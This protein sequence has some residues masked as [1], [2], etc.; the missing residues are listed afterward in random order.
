MKKFD[1][2]R[3]VCASVAMATVF[4][5]SGFVFADETDA[6]ED[7]PVDVEQT[8]VA[9]ETEVELIDEEDGDDVVTEDPVAEE[10]PE[11]IDD[12]EVTDEE[13][14]DETE[15]AEDEEEAEVEVIDEEVII[16]EDVI[17][18][19]QIIAETEAEEIIEIEEETITF[20]EAEAKNG[21]QQED[22]SWY[23]YVNGN[24]VSGWKK[25]GK[26]WYYFDPYN[27]NRMQ[28]G[29]KDIEGKRFIFDN[30]GIMLTGWVQYSG[31][32]FYCTSSGAYTGWHKI[33]KKWY[34]FDT[35]YFSMLHN[36][37]RAIDGKR[38]CFNTNGTMCTGWAQPYKYYGDE[39]Y[40]YC[41]SRG[42][43]VTG[44]KKI[45][46]KWYYFDSDGEMVTGIVT[47]K[48][49]T[50]RNATYGFASNG[51]MQTG[52]F[53]PG[54]YYYST[55]YY[56]D[57]SGRGV[58]GWKKFS[59]KWYYFNNGRMYTG[60][61]YIDGKNYYFQSYE[62]DSRGRQVGTLGA[63]RTGWVEFYNYY[64]EV[65][66]KYYG[67]DGARVN[68]WK[69]I[70]GK[71]Y[72]FDTNNSGYMA[73]GFRWVYDSSSSSTG[74]YYFFGTNGV[75][76]TGWV[77]Y[78]NHYSYMTSRGAVTSSWKKIGKK[79]YYFDGNSYMVTGYVWIDGVLYH[80][81]DDGHCYNPSATYP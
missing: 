72:Y 24:K 37:I 59:G 31:E 76:R 55:W 22:G 33:G 21:W 57:N 14:V 6:D 66:Y 29:A 1:L 53:T 11:V 61:N 77:Y 8:E 3:L 54:D 44:W 10:E 42:E 63:M 73:T 47:L 48:D 4:S 79:W 56:F 20:E 69:K 19:D 27:G 25:I 23:Y 2:K 12:E 32:W 58:S 16:D 65:S 81:A 49:E 60:E 36:T 34:Y 46:K 80:F 30:D 62:Y 5:A 38:Y 67:S 9:D 75:M 39:S 50:G 51:A 26:H 13:P 7:V 17:V 18:E 68:G 52:W 28:R 71:W 40:Y 70:S 74:A 43:L 41:N 64:D 35:S 45:G 78:N 15:P